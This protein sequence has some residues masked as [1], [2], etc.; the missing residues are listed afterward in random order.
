MVRPRPR[1]RCIHAVLIG[2]ILLASRVFA[3]D[4][5]PYTLTLV[6][7]G[8]AAIDQAIADASLLARLREEVPLGPFALIA[9][10]E[11]DAARFDLILRSFGHYD[12]DIQVRI[13]GRGID[14]PDL[15]SLL[16]A[17]PP[18]PPAALVVS[19]T[20]GPLY[21]LGLVRLDGP[22]TE[23]ARSAFTLTPGDPARAADVLAAGE[24]VLDALR[25]EGFPL[26][27]VPA[28]EVLVDHDSRTMEVVFR[29]EPGPR[30]PLGEIH[31]I[32]L[33]RLREPAALRRLGLTAGEPYSPSR[34]EQA[35]RDLLAGGVLAWARLTPGAEPDSQGR[36]P[37]TLELAERPPR[38]IR[39]AGAFS[40]DEGL[41][42]SSSWTHRNLFGGGEQLTLR[43][44]IGQIGEADPN[45]LSYLAS[46]SLRLPDLWARDLDLRLDLG[47]VNESLD[48]YDREAVTA[49]AI[50]ERRFTRWRRPRGQLR[51]SAGI[52][53][54][55]ARIAQNGPA[56]DYQLLSLPLTIGYDSSDAPLDPRRGL[57]LA[58][59]V[60]PAQVLEGEASGF[61]LA[62]AA[63]FSYL[64][65]SSLL[66]AGQRDDRPGAAQNVLAGRLVLGS[67]VGAPPQE[68][69]P[70]WR[71]Y[72]GGGGSVRGYPYQ[73]IGPR[74]PFGSPAGGDGLL[75]VALE[76]RRHLGQRWGAVAFADAGAVSEDGI[77][78]TGALSIGIGLGLRYFTPIGP[79]R[80]DIATPLDHS[81][82][83]SPIQLY[84]GIGQAF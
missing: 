62:R 64:D 42:L 41:T 76:L 3:S 45:A 20:P 26:A 53:F 52:A 31:V 51:G 6:P 49:G 47:A 16:D 32:G 28:P 36:L 17:R 70:D 27:Q 23:A 83:G 24:S 9:R 75:E 18:A 4:P 1:R 82:G 67:I 33:E 19:L 40:S 30:L 61:F 12:A 56:R 44:D 11:S 77:P 15:L 68:V 84:I 7:T 22:V 5:L 21:R 37:L 69:P 66:R 38:V 55:R 63:V 58:A 50:L 59:Q 60:T 48:A 34:L 29:A 8:D 25:E 2:L 78:G 10:A 80:V 54:E 35:R 81:V 79:V 65:L 13:D 39:L 71:F 57:R 74:T 72:A 14:D 73:S 43:A 46:G